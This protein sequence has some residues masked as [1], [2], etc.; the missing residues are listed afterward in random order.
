LAEEKV[1]TGE[2]DLKT[3]P[4]EIDAVIA[5]TPCTEGFQ[6]HVTFP[7]DALMPMHF[8]IF[9]PFARKVTFPA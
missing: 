5:T 6:S 3:P 1:K 4:W 9:L 8:A 2:E 7:T